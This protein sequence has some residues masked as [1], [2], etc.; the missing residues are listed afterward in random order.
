MY[1]AAPFT[2]FVGKLGPT[3]CMDV[4]GTTQIFSTEPEHIKVNALL[5]E[6]EPYAHA[7]DFEA[8]SLSRIQQFCK[9]LDYIY[10]E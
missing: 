6:R 1:L 2:E 8:N 10:V 7:D 9:R 3:F 5:N 4:F